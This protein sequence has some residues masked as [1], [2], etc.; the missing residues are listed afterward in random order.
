[1][2]VRVKGGWGGG[3]TIPRRDS[4]LQDGLGGGVQ[5]PPNTADAASLEA[6]G[7]AVRPRRLKNTT[8]AI[9]VVGIGV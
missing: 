9:P 7:C 5:H 6:R 4:R 1:M 3:S 2:G 8:N